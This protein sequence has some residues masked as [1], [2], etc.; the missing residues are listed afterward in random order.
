MLHNKFEFDY[1]FQKLMG[2]GGTFVDEG[3][4]EVTI[5]LDK[6]LIVV[7][8]NSNDEFVGISS[9]TINQDFMNQNQKIALQGF[10][11]VEQFYNEDEV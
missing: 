3:L 1:D 11:D 9:I 7:Q 6:Y 4:R 2:T 5:E 8:L 10:H